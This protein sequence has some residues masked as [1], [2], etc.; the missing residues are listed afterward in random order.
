MKLT[1]SL[2][3]AA[4]ASGYAFGAAT[5]YTT[6]VGYVGVGN[7]AGVAVPANTDMTFAIPLEKSAEWAGA[8]TSV[9]GNVI[10]FTGTTFTTDQ[11]VSSTTPYVVKLSNGT[12][13]GLVALITANTATTITVAFQ[14]SDTLTGVV[15]GDLIAIRKAWTL[16]T[17][18]AGNTLPDYIE[19]H[20]WQGTAVGTDNAPDGIY[21]CWNG[22]WYDSLDDSPADSLILYPNEGFRIRNST[23][24]GIATLTVSG[25]VPVAN[26]RIQIKGGALAQDTRIS[27]FGAVDQPISTSGLGFANYD[28]LFEYSLTATGTDNAPTGIYYLWDGGWYDSLDDSDVTATLKLKAG[29]GY[30]YRTADGTP[31]GVSS[32]APAYASSL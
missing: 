22:G 6:P 11:W 5:A 14:N 19:F 30:V 8:V 4:A 31:S 23:A 12:K 29:V 21:Y 26:S 2:I 7:T 15:A 25:E 13:S 27:F 16:G 18:F 28:Q 3:L 10:T 9:S 24:S 32:H 20:L 17:V 1:Y